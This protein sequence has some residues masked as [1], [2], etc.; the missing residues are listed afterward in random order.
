MKCS[1][2][3]LLLLHHLMNVSHQSGV[4][5]LNVLGGIFMFKNKITANANLHRSIMGPSLSSISIFQWQTT[6]FDRSDIIQWSTLSWVSETEVNNWSHVSNTE[7]QRWIMS[8]QWLKW[9]IHKT[10]RYSS[11]QPSIN[12]VHG[13]GGGG[14]LKKMIWVF[15]FHGCHFEVWVPT[16]LYLHV[17]QIYI[18]F[19]CCVAL[20]SN[21]WGFSSHEN[22]YLFLS[23]TQTPYY[24]LV[25]V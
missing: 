9:L 25:P 15:F 7:Q 3:G 17:L 11:K 24:E 21:V 22:S 5:F 19:V 1:Y 6:K 10:L 12:I 14:I 20:T 23:K 16:K 13:R 18:L 2:G 8:K 4:I